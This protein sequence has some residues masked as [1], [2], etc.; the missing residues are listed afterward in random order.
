VSKSLLKYLIIALLVAV[1]NGCIPPKAI[2]LGAPDSKDLERSPKEKVISS[3]D[4][5][6]F[7]RVQNVEF[8][9]N[10]WTRNIPY[11]INL[12]DLVASHPVRS[13][14]VIQRDTIKYEFYR[15]DIDTFELHPSYSMAK[16]F[17]SALLGIA[18]EEGFIKSI[19][20]S[21]ITYLPE[22]S[23]VQNSEQLT[24]RH[25]LN[26]TSGFKKKLTTDIN[27]Y[28]ARDITKHLDQLKIESLPGTK[29]EYINV[30][31][32]L[33]GMVLNRATKQSLSS[34]MQEKIW[35]PIQA[36]SDAIWSTDKKNDLVKAYCC[37]GAV[38]LDYAKF[39]RLFL[40]EGNWNGEQI[41]SKNWY[42]ES[43]QR[44]TLSGSSW[45]YNHSWHIGL[46]EYGDFMAIGLYKQHIYVHP[47]KQLII[48]LL[49]DKEKKLRAERVNWWYIFRQISDQI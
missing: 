21:V 35:Q 9:I 45:N 6:E 34:Y 22:I 14:L 28:Y 15:N 5:F 17:T 41:I 36:C 16:S 19:D 2:I 27:I 18:I 11:F 3:E 23:E 13:L 48:V 47:K 40:N 12:D 24:I 31:T 44:D 30:N 25:L 7:D 38:V 1:T 39:G 33:L 20:D 43:I 42:N 32:Q 26:H 10:D 37:F 49:N 8:K 46:K 4:C 29:Q